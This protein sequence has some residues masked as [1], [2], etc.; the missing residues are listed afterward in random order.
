MNFRNFSFFLLLLPL[1]VFSQFEFYNTGIA[2]TIQRGAVLHVQG[3][4]TN[5]VDVSTP[6]YT[7]VGTITNDGLIELEGDLSISG[8]TTFSTSSPGNATVKFVGNS[9]TFTQNIKGTGTATFYNLVLDELNA[10]NV[11]MMQTNVNVTGSLVFN[12]AT[13]FGTG[14]VTT[15]TYPA[16][17]ITGATNNGNGGILQT[18]DGN[19]NEW[20]LSILNPDPTAINGYP[21]LIKGGNPSTAYVLTS[22]QSGPTVGGA[23]STPSPSNPDPN[24]GL[25]R[26]INASYI[27]SPDT[28]VAYVFPIGTKNH[29]FNGIR[30]NFTSI[31]A[32]TQ[33]V[34]GKFID[35][36]QSA[37]SS[38]NGGFTGTIDDICVNCW[39]NYVAPSNLG[40]NYY[41]LHNPYNS[42]LQQWFVLQGHVIQ[43][44]FW[45]FTGS[46]NAP[47]SFTYS[48]EAF[49]NGITQPSGPSSF[50]QE[51]WRVLKYD[52]GTGSNGIPNGADTYG[53]D[54]TTQD[55]TT[56]ITGQIINE[57]GGMNNL[58][59]YSLNTGGYNSINGGIPGG[60]YSGFSDFALDKSNSDVALP[61]T[62]IYLDATP[63]NNSYI[64]VQWATELEINNSGFKVERS[65]DAI[66]F[67][68]IGWVAGHDNS[69]RENTYDYN[70]YNVAPDT[71]Y[72]YRLMQVDNNGNQTPTEIVQASLTGANIF[73]IGELFPNPARDQ[74]SL[75]I[76]TSEAKNIDVKLYDIIGQQISDKQ[77]NLLSGVNAISLNAKQLA[78]G[79][80]TVIIDAGDNIYTRKLVITR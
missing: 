32:G 20:V 6:P 24:G 37:G 51:I 12:S 75:N 44:G 26:Q 18:Y 7:N 48:I 31:L 16:T 58:L 41:F 25:L 38:S 57:P 55:W 49:P 50:T 35:Y 43:H 8:A 74:S 13:I 15:N 67:I 29:G 30:L 10:G 27:V 39:G 61:V 4:L 73:T 23:P 3:T 22:G 69:N 59:Q 80:Y 17:T 56:Q 78:G 46:S 1:S 63:V 47:G 53:Y 54:P 11:V 5:A 40:W 21:P 76:T 42:N 62:L 19:N 52:N 79:T 2:I 36:E 28:A 60:L 71:I 68:E 77:Y 65:S 64:Q 34:Q 14:A 9:T 66:N 33:T 70:D 45:T 72:Y